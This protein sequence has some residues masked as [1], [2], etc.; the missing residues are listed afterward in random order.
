MNSEDF[1]KKLQEQVAEASGNTKEKQDQAIMR[2]ID[3]WRRNQTVAYNSFRNKGKTDTEYLANQFAKAGV[4]KT[5]AWEY[6][7]HALGAFYD[8]TS[9]QSFKDEF[10][11]E[12]D[13]TPYQKEWREGKFKNVK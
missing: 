5:A 2:I 13:S 8:Q 11:A 12:F 9:Q 7:N 3:S 4:D 10:D 1:M 6:T